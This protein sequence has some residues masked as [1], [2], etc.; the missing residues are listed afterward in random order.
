MTHFLLDWQLIRALELKFVGTFLFWKST[1]GFVAR[2]LSEWLERHGSHVRSIK[3]RGRGY[4]CRV[5]LI[6]PYVFS[7]E[8]KPSLLQASSPSFLIPDHMA[9]CLMCERMCTHQH[10]W[11]CL[12]VC[13]HIW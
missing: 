10:S 11:L 6:C 5:R 4:K 12:C 3:R 2:S 7:S 8:I 1:S 9:A 13:V